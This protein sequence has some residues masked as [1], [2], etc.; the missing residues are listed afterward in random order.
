MWPSFSRPPA[1][2]A[3]PAGPGGGSRDQALIAFQIPAE[4]A[5]PAKSVTPNGARASRIALAMAGKAAI[6]PASPQPLTPSGLVVQRV[7]LK[8]RL[9]DGRSSARGMA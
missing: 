7:P 4:V 6:A 2:P 1:H 9:K 8:P 3:L 5:G